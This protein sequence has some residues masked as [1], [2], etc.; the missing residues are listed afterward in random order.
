VEP[1]KEIIG[2]ATLY[3]GDSRDIL[4]IIQKADTVVTSPPYD[5]LRSYDGIKFDFDIFKTIAEKL[6]NNL[7]TGGVIVWV[8]GDQ[9]IN[10]SETMTSFKQA[11]YFR[12]L[13]LRLHDTM[14][15][16]KSGLPFPF[17]NRYYNCFEY[18]F[19]FSDGKPKTV[20]LIKDHKN[21]TAGEKITGRWRKFDGTMK[22]F[23]GTLQGR[24]KKEYSARSNVWEYSVG[25][26]SSTKD[27]IAFEHPAIFPEKL[28][29]DHII[30]WSNKNDIIL[31]PFM[32]SGTTGKA[33]VELGRRFIGIKK[34]K[35][36]FDI[37]C[38]RIKEAAW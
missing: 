18:M 5:N 12:E 2:N 33:A 31:D 20:N 24:V 1:R 8:V 10:G 38:K 17:P 35:K 34:K 26:M 22:E 14:I 28:A 36:Y 3:L 27:K 32:G 30:T 19:I 7:V 37:A 15:Y 25:Y 21:K 6:K 29:Q 9:T 16:K 13:G 11:L 23:N 4:P